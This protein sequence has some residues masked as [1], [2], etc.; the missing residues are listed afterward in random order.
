MTKSNPLSDQFDPIY[1]MAFESMNQGFCLLEKVN[2][3][4]DTPPDF[5]YLL[6]NQAFSQ[7]AGLDH[8]V[9]KTLRQVVPQVEEPI[10]VHYE[11][12]AERGVAV[13][14][15]T[16]VSTLDRW[17][18]THAFRIEA[19]HPTQIAV[20]FTDITAR[21]QTEEALRQDEQ[22][23]AFL[24][25]LSDELRPLA[26]P[27]AIQAAGS[28]MTMTYFGAD[29]SYYCEIDGDEVHIRQDAYRPD[30]LSVAT[31]YSLC[32]MPL[33]KAFC[34]AGRPLEV[35]D[36]YTTELLDEELRQL[37]IQ[38]N[39]LACIIVP[40]IKQG[41]L[42][43]NFC[44]SQSS[45]RV[46]TRLEVDLAQA[47]AERTWA[48]VKQA[49]AET[50]LRES[51]THF[52][53]TIEAAQ[54]ATWDWNL[55]TNEVV[56]NEEHFRLFGMEPRP[57]PIHPDLFM[58][59]VH[60]D[61]RD[62]VS[63]LLQAAIAS[64]G[65]F[66]TE[67]C[68]RLDD[69][70]ERWMSGYGRVVDEGE[71]R[72]T[73]MS[74]V[75]FDVNKRKRAED[76]LRQADRRK[77]EFLAL[78]AHELRNP[79]ATLSNTLQLLELTGGQQPKLTLPM[80]LTLMKRE[81]THLV[82]LVDDLLDVSRI[83]QGKVS[84]SIERLD[85]VRL[86]DEAVE[87][88]RMQFIMANQNLNVSLPSGPIYLAGDA[89]RLRQVVI[90][91]LHNAF[92]F[93]PAGGQVWLNLD[94][95]ADEAVLRVRDTGIGIP[96]HELGRIFD[97]FAQ[98]DTSLGRSQGGLG[99]GLTLVHELVSLHG[100]WVKAHS[101]GLNQGSEFVVG[102][103]LLEEPKPVIHSA[104]IYD[105]SPLGGHRLM[106]IDDNK[107]AAETLSLLLEL[108]GYTVTTVFSGQEGILVAE[109]FRPTVTLC[110]ISML[111]LDGYETCRL[112]RQQP[113]GQSMILIA[114]TGY[115]QVDDKRR[116]K[117]AGFDHHLVK[118]VDIRDLSSLLD[119]LPV[120]G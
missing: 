17:I 24:L 117:E 34:Q 23:Q 92:K 59:H 48:A 35:V 119:G 22:R 106:V 30:L 21:K 43:G 107:A 80:A 100:G 104:G 32:G 37:C 19:R 67:F 86:V 94:L 14:F 2:T 102:L 78:L 9:G 113:W 1:R 70:S 69:G 76:A 60:P 84:L 50:A 75:M 8:V 96:S 95:V 99:L 73:R 90:N 63:Q 10:L 26:D 77:D 81:V 109:S 101:A 62:R 12:V 98:V 53:L 72:A 55:V 97:M 6:T 11:E 103:R 28:Q 5:R 41:Q 44:I 39:I 40:V 82:R 3:P 13:H 29:R 20:L 45:P 85:L 46:W 93:T 54:V 74:G 15:E 57:N 79:L 108:E 105:L 114:L 25:Q 56:W 112:I 16:Y 4:T 58:D 68:A 27:V 116:T 118:P 115:G 88:A 65:V 47:I 49:R 42:V 89:A 120:A 87:A 111:G 61:E 83:S 38:L 91:L 71:G 51:E 7:H 31:R 18:D 66:D 52:R 110:D 64:R 36:T 33:F